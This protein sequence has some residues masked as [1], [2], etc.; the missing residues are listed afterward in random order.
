MPQH[1]KGARL[2]WRADTK[3]YII[4]DG[5]HRLSTGTSDRR[6][7]E[8]ILSR[9]I[10][11]RDR[12]TAGP[13]D[14]SQITVAE[15]LEH[16]AAEH[17]PTCKDPARIGHAVA[18]LVPILGALPVSSITGETCR[19]FGRVRGKAPGTIRKELGT[20]QAALNYCH[21]EGYL[22]A[23]PKVRL[24]AKPTPR[25][26]WLSRDEVAKLLRA[27]YRNPKTRH[28]VPFILVA[29]YT[30]TRSDAILRLRF[31]PNTYGGWIDLERGLM[32]R[33]GVGEAE[34][35]KRQ[36]PIP[37]PR[38]LLAHLRRWR[39]AGAQHVVEYKG[40]R[41][42]SVKHAWATA[43]AEAGI[44]HC[45]RHDLRRTA[46]TWAM[47]NGIDKWAACGFFGLTMDV[48]ESTYGHHHPEYL[49]S[50]VEA[51]ERRA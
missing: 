12:P 41:V 33:R 28:V 30:G 34:T 21:A 18:A 26:R 2:Q 8:S 14:P 17:A 25:D 7:A 27:A 37:L 3:R 29:I 45:T 47:Q 24:P 9:Y 44:E 11:E 4:R 1:S 6:E 38:R 16:Y 31:M 36:P 40:S 48:L 5:S 20:L 15:V 42:A 19:H 32:H 49:R 46:V 13:R 22:T 35:K 43:L 10:A 50:A 39:E 51:M 23:A